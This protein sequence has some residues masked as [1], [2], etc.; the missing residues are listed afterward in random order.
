MDIQVLG[1]GSTGNCYRISGGKT[2]LLLDCGLPVKKI[3]EGLKFRLSDIDGCLLTHEHFDHSKAARDIIKSGIDV[4]MSEGTRDAL[5]INKSHRLNI[6]EPKK[7]FKLGSLEIM[8]FDTQHDAK[9]PLGYLIGSNATRE[10]LLYATDTYYLKYKFP[11]LTHILI[12]CNYIKDILDSNLQEGKVSLTLRDRLVESHFSLDNL[13]N[14]FRANDL[15]KVRE[16]WLI[17]MSDGN[18]DEQRAK[19]EVQEVTGKL[20]YVP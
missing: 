5:N 16:I 19:K 1:T 10:V 14:F 3:K 20:V 6:V 2:S 13:K 18:C 17:H 9:E 4:Y 8:P 15:S 12:E 11:G 7:Q